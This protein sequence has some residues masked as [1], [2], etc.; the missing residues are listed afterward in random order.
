M[1]R[2]LVVCPGRGS[3]DRGS[4]GQL[5]NRS[6]A[7]A[8]VIDACDAYRASL[9]RP[10]MREL[11][12]AERH[13]ARL[14][15]AGEHASLL[16]FTCSLAD[17]ADLREDLE[18][19]GVT[20]NSMG[21]YTALGASGALDMADA[22]RLVETMGWYQQGHVVGGQLLTPVSDAHWNMDPERLQAV[23]EAL[24]SVRGAGHQAD[25]SI[26]LGGF[27]VLGAD[28]GGIRALMEALPQENRGSRNFPLQLPLH[29]AFHTALL[30][31][32]SQRAR[33]DLVDLAFRRPKVPLIDGLGRVHTRW[34]ADPAE[35]WDYTLGAQVTDTYDFDIAVLTALQYTAPDIVVVLGP[36]NSLGGPIARIMVM[37]G[38]MGMR[39]KADFEKASK[40]SSPLL[41]FGLAPQRALLT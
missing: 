11:D 14:H 21:W 5:S 34:S 19:V 8:A 9:G 22:M 35:L 10:T 30:T 1:T 24:H 36:G 33:Q 41:S 17:F 27:A 16:T 15:V 13:S 18:V 20:G 7:A 3:Y 25:W 2:T 4:L 32:T 6:T 26:R 38:W 12:G 39:T 37:N 28:Q 29:S 40:G 23:E 31:E